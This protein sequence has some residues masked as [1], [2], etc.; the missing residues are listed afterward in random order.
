MFHLNFRAKNLKIT[1]LIF[2]AK[3]QIA[4]SQKLFKLLNFWT[5]L[6]ENSKFCS[7][8]SQFW[9]FWL[10]FQ[11][12]TV[13]GGC[14]QGSPS[15]CMGNLLLT[16]TMTWLHWANRLPED[17]RPVRT[18]PIWRQF[19]KPTTSMSLSPISVI[20]I[21]SK[22]RILAPKLSLIYLE[23]QEKDQCRLHC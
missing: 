4:L 1:R 8:R 19:S 5:L 3:I 22:I 23:Q 9:R 20:K 6:R 13:P 10:I 17:L 14:S 11:T 16:L 2:A 15:T 7:L 18:C 12:L 21:F